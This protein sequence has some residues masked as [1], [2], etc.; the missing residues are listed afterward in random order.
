MSAISPVPLTRRREGEAGFVSLSGDGDDVGLAV[1]VSKNGL[2]DV[3]LANRP[4]VQD[5]YA[6]AATAG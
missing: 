4:I 6:F 3:T 5:R 1:I 2:N